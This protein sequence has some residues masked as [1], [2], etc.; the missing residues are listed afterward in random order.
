M[1]K[2]IFIISLSL[3]STILKSQFITISHQ[4]QIDSFNIIYPNIEH[5]EKLQ[6]IGKDVSDLNGLIQLSTIR[7]LFISKTNLLTLNGLE[8]VTDNSSSQLNSEIIIQDND[9]LETLE[10]IENLDIGFLVVT[11]NKN[12]QLCHIKS[13]CDFF[14]KQFPYYFLE[15]GLACRNP[16]TYCDLE[17]KLEDDLN[18]FHKGFELD[19]DKYSNDSY[20]G[21]DGK[22]I[23]ELTNSIEEGE[24]SLLIRNNSYNTPEGPANT[25]F[26]VD[27]QNGLDSAT[28][29][30]TY[31]CLGTGFC[32][33]YLED[34]EKNIV[35]TDPI[36]RAEAG[37][38]SAYK[39]CMQNV[40][41]DIMEI[42]LNYNR[43]V[44][45]SSPVWIPTGSYGN[46]EFVLD[47]INIYIKN[48]SEIPKTNFELNLLTNP[49]FDWLILKSNRTQGKLSI[50]DFLGRIVYSSEFV[51]SINC[52][53]LSS[54]I[55]IL[56][57]D[58]CGE[59]RSQKFIKT[60][61]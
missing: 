30:F 10:G 53:N 40:D 54:G 42:N 59:I 19:N 31:K 33:M 28:I 48:N 3:I 51:N 6:I 13:V 52:S 50:Y 11:N 61:K 24:F 15:N 5:V 55:Y 32:E 23:Y 58:N 18:I 16:F 26:H 21:I 56:V 44:F 57:Y 17:C 4:N 7:E 36:W 60:Q 34:R 8:N 45:N 14:K 1:K 37:D 12:L 47:D 35:L 25:E 49:V 22:R 38:N 20:I 9:F 2:Y 41:L 39:V 46:C 43:L 29:E 27:F